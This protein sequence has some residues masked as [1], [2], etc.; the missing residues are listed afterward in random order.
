MTELRKGFLP[1]LFLIAAIL[2]LVAACS[3]YGE[4]VAPLPVPG[5]Q[6]NAVS[7]DGAEIVARGYVGPGVAEDAFG[8]DIRK[9]GLLPVQFV[10]DNQSGQSV[11]IESHD[12]LLLD[13]DG[14]AWPLLSSDKATTRVRN[15]VRTGESIASG[16]RASLLTGLAG[17]VAGAAIGIVTG[18]DVGEATGRGAA[19]G[20]AVGALGKGTRR[21]L[22][23]D[24]EI[25]GDMLEK[26]LTSRPIVPGAL[27]HGFL[28]FPGLDS[29][30]KSVQSL[31]LRIHVGEE[32]RVVSIPVGENRKNK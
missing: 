19:A 13:R 28:F 2:A 6:A 29:E 4:R 14:N 26:S 21:Y 25:S 27:V 32:S 5:A 3:T 9:A 20:A 10:L 31:R 11:S 15:N 12:A 22:E 1:I 24:Y 8:F 30:A 16:A 17:A 18:G 23:L 7:V